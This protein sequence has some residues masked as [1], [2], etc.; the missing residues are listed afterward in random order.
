MRGAEQDEA[1]VASSTRRSSVVDLALRSCCRRASGT[2][3]IVRAPRPRAPA[4]R[5]SGTGAV[6][7]LLLADVAGLPLERDGA[8]DLRGR[9]HRQ[10]SR[11]EEV[12]LAGRQQAGGRSNTLTSWL[13]TRLTPTMTSSS[14]NGLP[15]LSRRCCDVTFSTTRLATEAVRPA[16]GSMLSP[17][18]VRDVRARQDRQ[19]EHRHDRRQHEREEQLAVEAPAD[20]AQERRPS[21]A[22]TRRVARGPRPSSSATYTTPANVR[23]SAIAIR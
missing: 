10:A 21:R 3:R 20:L 11:R 9:A 17:Q 23:I 15:P 1:T 19:G 22:G 18:L 6:A 5:R 13:I 7:D 4:R 14:R 8:I 16:A 2:V 12:A